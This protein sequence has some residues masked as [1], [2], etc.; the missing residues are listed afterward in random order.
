MMI[1]SGYPCT[2]HTVH[3]WRGSRENNGQ[4]YSI[5]IQT[6]YI[7]CTFA[8]SPGQN[9]LRHPK[10]TVSPYK[11]V[12]VLYI[13]THGHAGGAG[14]VCALRRD[15]RLPPDPGVPTE[16]YP[17]Y[18]HG[19]C[20]QIRTPSCVRYAPRP[21]SYALNMLG[22]WVHCDAF[23]VLAQRYTEQLSAGGAPW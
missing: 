8:C 19:P 18:I 14:R 7:Y 17:P 21:V 1:H 10:R 6:Q 13:C 22:W 9:V 15:Y 4:T 16:S 23:L 20:G 5:T 11:H 3:M 12:Y 2:V